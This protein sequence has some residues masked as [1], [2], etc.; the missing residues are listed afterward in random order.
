MEKIPY[1]ILLCVLITNSVTGQK[2]WNKKELYVQCPVCYA[3]NEV[4]R[5][6][7]PPSQEMLNQL[8]SGTEKKSDI[9]VNYSLF[10]DEAKAAFEY[11]VDLWELIIESPVPIYVQ[12]NWRAL[13]QN[14]LGNCGP[15][16]YYTDIEGAPDEDRYYPVAVAEKITSREITG[17]S[18]PDISAMF[19]RKIQWYF[20]TDGNTPDSLYDFV[21]VVLHEMAHG[22]GFTGFFGEAQ[23]G[24]IY[25]YY[26]EGDATSFDRLVIDNEGNHLLDTL[27]FPNPSEELKQA[28]TSNKLYAESIS[29]KTDNNG[30][31]P[32]LYAPTIWSDGSS[33]YHLNDATYPFGNAN[34]LM[35]H[36]L[37][38]GEAIHDPGPITKG[39]MDDLGWKTIRI[40]H[41]PIKDIEQIKPLLFYVEIESDYELD[42]ASLFVVLSTDSFQTQ[43]DTLLLQA[44]NI[45]KQFSAEYLP[46]GGMDQIQYYLSSKDKKNREFRLPSKAPEKFYSVTIG[47]DNISPTIDHSPIAYYLL[48]GE[49]LTFTVQIDDNLGVDTTFVTYSINGVEQPP[50]GLQFNSGTKYSGT[51][52]FNKNALKDG[53][54]I[55]YNI[56]AV[57]S[58]VAQNEGKVT[59]NFTAE[60]IFPPKISY[61]NN[62]DS[63]TNDL[64]LTD[65]D[66]YTADDFTNAALHS[67][68]PYSSPETNDSNYNFSTILKQQIILQEEGTISYDEVVLVEPG[69]PL[70]TYGDEDFWDYVIMEG[71]KDSARTW[72][73]LTDGYDSGFNSNWKS[74]YNSLVTGQESQAKGTPELFI[75]H[76]FKLLNNGN[77]SVGDTILIRFRLYSDPYANGW[78]WAIDNLRIQSTV[79]ASTVVLSPGNISV[80]PNP[81]NNSLNVEIQSQKQTS[82]IQ[83]NLFNI[84]GQKIETLE[85]PN[86]SGYEKKYINTT[87]LKPGIY[88]VSINENGQPVY[89]KKVIKN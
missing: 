77:F 86:V 17:K 84:Y 28:F 49:D 82:D 50:F 63:Q 67:P 57:D 64:V 13:D 87:N 6:F 46:A 1:L 8:K 20:G 75:N 44:T 56:V 27:L 23:D 58:S 2:L 16:D 43:S 30:I 73:P 62:F 21:S 76:E 71:S 61:T 9:I 36:A 53:D 11:A 37:G 74:E 54:V 72:L 45:T 19:N 26:N 68:H 24:G 3:S 12:A 40:K 52:N 25:T 14:I 38:K 79:D 88:L 10:P 32:R 69:D 31:I 85:L 35:T 51:F 81:F 41:T 55:S 5:V 33:I 4:H 48:N 78:G 60:G 59:F 83:I 15:T 22:L 29:A 42:T 80:F 65:F 7:I 39:I 70:A 47:P 18:S 34:S 66:I 89:S